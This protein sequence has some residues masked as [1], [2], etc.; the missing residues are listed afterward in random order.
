MG[1]TGLI[2]KLHD[3]GLALVGPRPN[4]SKADEVLGTN[5]RIFLARAARRRRRRTEEVLERKNKPSAI[6]IGV[7]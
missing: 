5:E 2:R 7:Q 3:S 4:G 6:K 1:Q